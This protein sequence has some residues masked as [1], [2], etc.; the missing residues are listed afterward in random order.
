MSYIDFIKDT[1]KGKK[2][3]GTVTLGDA[4]IECIEKMGLF[5]PK[6]FRND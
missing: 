3:N 6:E 5:V 2:Y 1:F 4:V